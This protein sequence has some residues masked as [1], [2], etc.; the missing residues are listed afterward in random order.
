MSRPFDPPT[1]SMTRASA[2]ERTTTRRWA[3]VMGSW[4]LSAT[5]VGTTAGATLQLLGSP[6]AAA[7]LGIL[8]L[9]AG[10]GIGVIALLL[11]R[12]QASRRPALVTGGGASDRPLHGALLGLPIALALPALLWMVVVAS[13]A[14]GS[15]LIGAFFGLGAL[16]LAFA[17]LRVLAQHRLARALEALEEGRTPRS[18]DA[19]EVLAKSPIS[20]RHVR[21]TAQLSVAM[22]RLQE[23][24]GLEALGWLESIEVGS[25][26]AWAATGRA[27]ASLLLA[28]DPSDAESHLAAAFDSEHVNDVRAQADAV[29]VL[30][31]WRRDGPRAARTLAESLRS[32]SATPL[33]LALLA[34][35]R[36]LDGDHEGEDELSSEAVA[37][38]VDS[39]LGRAIP[40]LHPSS[41]LP[42]R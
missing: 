29:R 32:A 8:G 27:M 11:E 20:P 28:Q 9:F 18:T 13:V 7:R 37:T 42:M 35:L 31:V 14:M 25:A 1:S 16:G 33:H 30:I 36:A 21:T 24:R 3:L 17:G 15:A 19:L 26:A 12:D 22:S 5:A 38:M 41:S 40:E 6:N 10:L 34:R 2:R 4:G 23:G 39:G